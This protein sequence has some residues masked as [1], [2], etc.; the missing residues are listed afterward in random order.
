MTKA[1]QEE[2]ILKIT[3]PL[4]EDHL[5]I[6]KID[7]KEEISNLFEI[8]VELLFDEDNDEMFEVTPININQVL[9]QTVSIKL[10]QSNNIERIFTGIINRFSQIGRNH[11]FTLYK[12][13][14]VPP[15]W[16]LTQVTQSRIFQHKRVPDILKEV[17][18]GYEIKMQVQDEYKPRN[19]CVQYRETD[20]DFASRLMEEEGIYYYFEHTNETV[21]LILRDDFKSP[22]NCPNKFEIP[23]FNEELKVE[24]HWESAVKSIQT[25]YALHTGKVTVWDYNFEL[26]KKSLDAEELSQ[27]NVGGNRELES[28]TFPTGYARK[29]DGID[30]GGSEQ[31][32][33]LENVFPDIKRTARNKKLALDSQHKILRGTSDCATLTPGYRFQLKNHPN[34]ELS[35][36]YIVLS[37]SHSSDQYPSYISDLND[38]KAYENEF[39][40]IPHGEGKPEFRPVQKTPKPILHGSQT[41]FVVGPPGE[42]I[43]TDKYGRVKVQF[44]WDRTRQFSEDSS[45]WVRVGTMWAGKNWGSMFIPRIGMEVIVD[46]IEGDPDQPIITGS[47][48]NPLAMPPYKLPEEQTKMTIKSDSSKGGAGFNE[49]RFEDKKGSEQVFIHGEKDLDVRIKNDRR[50]WTGKDQH[51]IVKNDR[52]EKI[53]QDTHLL[54]ERHQF[55]EIKKDKHLT[56]GGDDATKVS[57]NLSIDVGGS[58]SFKT[59]GKHSSTAGSNYYIS[60][61]QV[62]IESTAGLTLKGPGGSV[63]ITPAGIFIT[64]NMVFINSGNGAL[65]DSASVPKAPTKPQVADIADD[66]KPGSKLKLDFASEAR[67]EKRHKENPNDENKKSWIALKMI[68][69]AGEPV[70]GKSFKVTTPD[71]SVYSGTT[72]KEG[73]GRVNAILPGNCEITFPDLDK[74]AWE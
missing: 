33:N 71:G 73:K 21:R 67:K 72:D 25:D 60:G 39:T 34:K 70:A 2:R 42:E 56:V 52:R 61:S 46:F 20:F 24:E 35:V 40:C 15:I 5:L 12:A 7:V 23:I 53:E 50:E 31:A 1:K 32:S 28:Y 14:I 18:T 6:N 16:K 22:E 13:T 26:T 57:S 38:E 43:F 4:G 10:T 65:S 3:T 54:V 51:L 64:G 68:N 17:F 62:V 27:F 41:A 30:S 66:A 48:Y 59:A 55:E 74:D 19:Y 49:L 8:N 47:V 44:H 29:Y 58:T 45:C 36:Q 63:S 9:G 69:E 37:V 11:R